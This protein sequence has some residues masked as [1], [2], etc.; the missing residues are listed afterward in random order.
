M[1]LS[2]WLV[3]LLNVILFSLYLFIWWYI[4]FLEID[5]SFVILD[6]RNLF[7]RR[8]INVILGMLNLGVFDCRFICILVNFL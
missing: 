7:F 8:F 6:I 3:I 2:F 1:I 5:K 4:V